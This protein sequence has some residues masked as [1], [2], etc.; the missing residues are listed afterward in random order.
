MAE[1]TFVAY[2]VDQL[3]GL[4]VEA[5]AMF[6]GYGLYHEDGIFGIV[7]EG[8]LYFKVDDETRSRYETAGMGPFTPR[9]GQTMRSY[10]E[11]PGDVLEDEAALAAWAREAVEAA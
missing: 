11:V 3:A 2:V 9:E 7:Y 5:R 10:R 4:D 1:D 8:R 6:G